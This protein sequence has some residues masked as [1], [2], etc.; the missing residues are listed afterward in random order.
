ML[1]NLK[2]KQGYREL[3]KDLRCKLAIYI[4]TILPVLNSNFSKVSPD[5]YT[6]SLLHII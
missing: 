6:F 2:F 4:L 1:I 3:L 5:I